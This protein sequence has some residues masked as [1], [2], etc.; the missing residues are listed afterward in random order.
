MSAMIRLV[1]LKY[2]GFREL[3]C[4]GSWDSLCKKHKSGIYLHTVYW[5]EK[6]IACYAGRALGGSCTIVRRQI[7]HYKNIIGGQ[8]E[9]P[10]DF[11]P[12]IEHDW[13]PGLEYNGDPSYKSRYED[14]RTSRYFSN[15]FNKS[16]YEKVVSDF[17]LHADAHKIYIANMSGEQLNIIK[18]AE[19][20]LIAQFKPY[21]NCMKDRERLYEDSLV[22]AGDL[23]YTYQSI[24]KNTDFFWNREK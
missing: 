17:F 7:D 4:S 2:N 23:R 15:I 6:E 5:Q 19:Q 3:L 22:H 8:C 16:T 20:A 24:L 9:V 10:R 18:Q 14:P 21:R 1:W 11:L 13:Y 12:S